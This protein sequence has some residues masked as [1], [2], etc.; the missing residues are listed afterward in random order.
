M[1]GDE[2]PLLGR[3]VCIA[4][5]IDVFAVTH[6][7]AAAYRM[8]AERSGTWFDPELVDLLEAVEGDPFWAR[9]SSGEAD[10]LVGELEPVRASPTSTRPVSTA[11]PARS[12]G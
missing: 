4:Q 7:L 11:S 9:L 5:S 12:R 2:I 6:G 8:A 10:E 1:R 3:L